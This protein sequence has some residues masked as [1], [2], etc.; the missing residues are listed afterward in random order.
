MKKHNLILAGIIAIGSLQSCDDDGGNGNNDPKTADSLE[1]PETYQWNDAQY[2]DQTAT[3]EL[4][5]ELSSAVGKANNGNSVSESNLKKIFNNQGSVVSADVSLADQI[6]QEDLSMF[7]GYFEKMD[8]LTN[9]PNANDTIIGGRYFFP[10]GVEPQQLIEKGLMGACLYYQAT[11]KKLTDLPSQTNE[12]PQ[13]GDKPTAREKQF[14]EAFGYLG[15]PKNFLSN[16]KD[17]VKG[18]YKNSSWFWGHYLRGRNSE[19]KN[20]E[21]LFNAFLKGR[22]AITQ[23]LPDKRE[24][25]VNTIYKEW[26]KLVA[27]NVAHYV[28]ATISDIENDA[29][30]SKWHHWSEAKAFTMC[31][32]YNPEKTISTDEI[33]SIMNSL[34]DSPKDITTQELESINQKLNGIYDFPSPITSF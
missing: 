31:L 33:N 15:V 8:N 5:T 34:G 7:E 3:I 11:S 12:N 21:T 9:D 20:K 14:D 17:E 2:E 30:G 23:Q 26:E 24:E 18:E 13:E 32:R 27:S 28:N 4:L 6:P 16:D 29:T 25:A 19:L 1:L 10:N 22:K